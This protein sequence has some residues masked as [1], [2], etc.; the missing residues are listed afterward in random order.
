MKK[1]N[2]IEV[3]Y[4]MLKGIFTKGVHITRTKSTGVVTSTE[5]MKVPIAKLKL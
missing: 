2:F 4:V 3:F 5:K 1:L